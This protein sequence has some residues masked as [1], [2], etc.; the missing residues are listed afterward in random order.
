[1]AEE[2]TDAPEQ[3]QEPT[4]PPEQNVVGEAKRRERKAREEAESLKAQLAELAKWKEE[5]EAQDLSETEREKNAREKAEK[6]AEEAEQ[7]AQ[8][9][10]RG[11]WVRDH[12]ARQGFHDPA[13]AVAFSD[14]SSLEDEKAAEKAVKDL[15]K[16]KPHLLKS[17]PEP[18]AFGSLIESGTPENGVPT[19]PD[20]EPDV[21]RGLGSDLLKHLAGR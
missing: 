4:D 3:A 20:G 1:M 14:L 6:R 16:S 2:A 10:E 21:K 11:G 8:R 13:D 7:R 18:S 19:T 17:E 12:A 9:L 15:A 5:R